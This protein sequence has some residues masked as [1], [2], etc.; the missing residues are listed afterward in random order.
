MTSPLVATATLF[1]GPLRAFFQRGYRNV[2]AQEAAAS[3]ARERAV[4]V[5]VREDAEWRAGHVPAARHVPLGRLES[6]LA[7]LPRDRPV[8]VVCASGMRSRSA[9]RILARNG[10]AD[11]RNLRGGMAAWRSAGLPLSR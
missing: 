11:V 5:D 6:R 2:S 9:A 8:V 1:L 3:A 4:L 7:E 10:F